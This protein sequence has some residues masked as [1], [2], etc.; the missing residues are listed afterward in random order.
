M[1]KSPLGHEEIKVTF[2][3]FF[4]SVT[5]IKFK[6]LSLSLENRSHDAIIVSLL[7]LKVLWGRLSTA[8]RGLNMKRKVE[9]YFCFKPRHLAQVS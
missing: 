7:T 6:V 2:Y 4:R 9:V 8:G 1:G 3:A 5:L